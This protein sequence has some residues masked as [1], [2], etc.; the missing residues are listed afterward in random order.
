MAWVSIKQLSAE[1]GLTWQV[2]E[3]STCVVDKHMDA[4]TL[5]MDRTEAL[6]AISEYC[7]RKSQCH[8]VKS[9]EYGKGSGI[10]K[11]SKQAHDALL[12]KRRSLKV[13]NLLKDGGDTT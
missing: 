5:V 6:K 12:W 7:K 1:T 3:I 9:K 2:I 13:L 10:E 11:R 4:G 8:A